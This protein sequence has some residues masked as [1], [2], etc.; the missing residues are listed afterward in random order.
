MRQ[1][2]EEFR[3][4]IALQDDKDELSLPTI[5]DVKKKFDALQKDFAALRSKNAQIKED[6]L[7]LHESSEILKTV[8]ESIMGQEDRINTLRKEAKEL[9]VETEAIVEK[10]SK[11]SVEAKKNLDLM[12]RLGSS[13]EIAKNV[14]NKFPSHEKVMVTLDKLRADEEVIVEKNEA[15]GK[16]IE[17]AGG[18]QITARQASELVKK[19]DEKIEHAKHDV[20]AL[21]AAL[22]DEKGTYLTFQKI[23]ERIVPSL[24]GYQTQLDMMEQRITKI[25]DETREQIKTI[26]SEA[27][28]LE[29]SLKDDTS[30]M[31][32][33]VKVAQ[34]IKQK[35]K[36][37]DD[38]KKSFDDLAEMSDNLN[39]RATLLSSEAKLLEIRASTGTPSASEALGIKEKKEKGVKQQ[40]ELSE[41]EE[42]EFRKKREELKKLIQKLWE[43]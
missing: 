4:K 7:S 1:N 8:T 16:I 19:L 37:L 9:A 24:E 2:L 13:V 31:G 18:K 40:L 38:I 34:E 36:L 35:K 5:K 42:L 21:E 25:N 12:E 3:K 11:L 41:E 39:K 10:T 33:M 20:D 23:K 14:I 22:N 43:E 26:K 15:L 32:E 30:Q 29:A 28:K 27:Q 6:M 17:A